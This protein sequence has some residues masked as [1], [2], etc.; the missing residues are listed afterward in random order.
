MCVSKYLGVLDTCF[1][2]IISLKQTSNVLN[3]VSYSLW[4][5]KECINWHTVYALEI[6]QAFLIFPRNWY[7]AAISFF[8]W[9]YSFDIAGIRQIILP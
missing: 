8:I 1:S 6:W 7:S 3:E 9:Q 2:F 5:I 4:K